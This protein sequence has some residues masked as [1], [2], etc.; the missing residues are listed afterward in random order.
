MRSRGIPMTSCRSRTSIRDLSRCSCGVRA[1]RAGLLIDVSSGPRRFTMKRLFR[2]D[3]FCIDVDV[4]GPEPRI[5]CQ[6]A[7]IV[8]GLLQSTGTGATHQVLVR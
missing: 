1:T 2:G 4:R 8:D 5:C 7:D 3:V 6:T